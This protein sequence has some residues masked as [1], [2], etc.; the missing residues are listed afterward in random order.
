MYA[1][2][3][4]P[5]TIAMVQGFRFSMKIRGF[6]WGRDR[7][8]PLIPDR[9]AWVAC[10]RLAGGGRRLTA[11]PVAELA[12]EEPRMASRPPFRTGK[13]PEERR[14]HEDLT[15]GPGEVGEVPTE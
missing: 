15:R 3:T 13:I 9:A 1:I 7:S 14:R 4:D 8:K 11:V 5:G 6:T 12:R 2:A 10:K